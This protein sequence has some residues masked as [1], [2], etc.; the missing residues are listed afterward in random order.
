MKHQILPAVLAGPIR[1]R[2][3]R[4]LVLLVLVTVGAVVGTNT[5]L[6]NGLKQDLAASRIDGAIALVRDEV[7]NLLTPVQQQ[8]LIIRD[9]LRSA[10]LTP[11]DTRALNEHLMPTLSHVRQIAGAVYATDS[12]AEYFLRRDGKVWMTRARPAGDDGP[13]VVTRWSDTDEPLSSTSVPVDHDPRQ[14][15]WYRAAVERLD[16]ADGTPFVWSTPYRFHSL[17]EPGITVSSGWRENDGLRVVALDVT[18]ASVVAAVNHLPLGPGGRG[19][20]F[21]ETG[22]VYAAG[23]PATDSNDQRD[24]YS[25]EQRLGGPLAFDAVAAWQSAG[26][27][28]DLLVRF[29]SGGRE[30]WGGFLPLSAQ[31]RDGWVGVAIPV[32]ETLGIL[33]SRWHVVA[34]T[35]LAILAL[36]IGLALL[37]VRRY[38]NQLRDLP[39]LAIDRQ[40]PE[41]DLFDLIGRGEGTHLELK[42]TMRT[43]LHTGKP[44]KE[45]ELAWLKGVA[46]FLN[47]EGGIL[48]IGVADDGEVLGLQADAFTNDDKCRLHFKSLIHQH[49][50]PEHARFLRFE[51]FSLDGKQIGAVECEQA[52]E[53]VFLRHGKGESFLIRNGPSSIELP[54]SRALGYIRGHF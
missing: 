6:I 46:A 3:F 34:I 30:W 42:S 21:T 28:A 51:L 26:E 40:D 45:I 8:L 48:L 7:R 54:I 39:K 15:P 32:S 13:F 37:V 1:G 50:G 10:D 47:T 36:G 16:Q 27:P 4:D 44:G 11:K 49:L 5:V 19:F 24:F 25:A 38:S 35:A 20:L 18:L 43:N 31:A 33:Q 29:E 14:R 22:G 41:R 17:D 12:G 53:P 23:D 52:D 9:A 2:L